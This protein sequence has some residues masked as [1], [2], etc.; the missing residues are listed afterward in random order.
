MRMS[1]TV[2]CR[3]HVILVLDGFGPSDPFTHIV[4]ALCCCYLFIHLVAA[5]LAFSQEGK[6]EWLDCGVC[7]W[8]YDLPFGWS[9]M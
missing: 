1:L 9:I 6:D 3:G 2:V 4:D 8:D 5:N 7:F